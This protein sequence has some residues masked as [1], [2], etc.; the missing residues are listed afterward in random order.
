ML[1][2]TPTT[3]VKVS[4]E[5]TA[6]APSRLTFSPGGSVARVRLTLFG[7]TSTEVVWESPP[8]S[9]AVRVIRYQTLGEVSM[10][11]AALNEPLVMPEVGGMTGWECRLASSWKKST[12]QVRA[13]APRVPSS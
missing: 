4:G 3:L 12:R 2:M 5:A 10:S 8:E 6:A 13:A 7:K 9:V 1:R 11:G